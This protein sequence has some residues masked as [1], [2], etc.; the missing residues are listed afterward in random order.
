MRILIAFYSRTGVTKKTC[1]A[2]AEALRA[3][4]GA[5]EVQVEEIIDREDRSGALGYARAGRDAM[6]KRT[7]EIEPVQAEVATYDLVV[8][9]TPVWAWTA[10][11]ACRAFCERFAAQMG[12]VAFVATMGG[13]G[14]RGAFQA[15]EE[16]C[17]KAPVATL[18]LRE[19]L[20][21][22]EEAEGFT[23]PVEAFARQISSAAGGA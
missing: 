12:A 19:R 20:V 2:I 23:Q 11:P 8:I 5:V 17:G 21:K 9:G 14:D 4:D 10:V 7:T 3:E 16:W 18:A 1:E 15:L 6:K 13:N 22:R